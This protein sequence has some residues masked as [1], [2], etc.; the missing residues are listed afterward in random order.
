[1]VVE[2]ESRFLKALDRLEKIAA[3]K[4]NIHAEREQTLEQQ[5]AILQEGLDGL[6]QDYEKMEAIFV[7]LKEQVK[8]AQTAAAKAEMNSETDIE[9]TP[10]FKNLSAERDA[11]KEE[12]EI[13][14]RD[15]ETLEDSFRAM[16]NQFADQE[17]DGQAFIEAM[18]NNQAG[19]VSSKQHEALVSE[20]DAIK[21]E[22]E[23]IKEIYV[24]QLAENELLLAEATGVERTK[25]S[26]RDSLDKSIAKLEQISVN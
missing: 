10:G 26:L 5:N 17:E 13:T 15:Y 16:K 7:E 21:Q 11:L 22:L 6:R 25:K 20:R 4:S 9:D 19:V 1:M 8:E 18:A 23:R 14:R 2:S 24:M 3:E 12:L